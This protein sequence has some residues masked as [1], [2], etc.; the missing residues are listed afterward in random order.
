MIPYPAF[1]DIPKFVA[2][3]KKGTKLVATIP[4]C[5]WFIQDN[6]VTKFGLHSAP[7]VILAPCLSDV[8]LF[9]TKYFSHLSQTKESVFELLVAEGRK[10]E[11]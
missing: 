10:I 6:F 5:L 3:E 8:F 2:P 11:F 1:S 9:A 7:F 4:S